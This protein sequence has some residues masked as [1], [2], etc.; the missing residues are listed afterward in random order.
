MKYYVSIRTVVPAYTEVEVDAATQSEAEKVV[1]D[2]LEAWGWNSPY[3]VE[4]LFEED[5]SSAETPE[6]W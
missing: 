4:A 1:N 6:K 2:S 3:V 5:Y